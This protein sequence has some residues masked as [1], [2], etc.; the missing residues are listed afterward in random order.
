MDRHPVEEFWSILREFRDYPPDVTGVPE[1]LPGTAAFAASAGLHRPP[2]SYDL[3]PFPFGG[4]MVVGHNLDSRDGYEQRRA[5]GISHGDVVTGTPPMSTW[6][7]LY[8]LVEL[9]EIDVRELFF[10][11]VLV[12]LKAGAPTGPF[13]AHRAPDFRRW[14]REFLERQIVTMRPAVMLVLGTRACRDVSAMANPTPWAG[15]GLPPPTPMSARISGHDTILVA[16]HHTSMQKRIAADAGALRAAW[17]SVR[18]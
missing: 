9:A 11:N 10:T 13:T 7:G 1:L 17:S 2:G 14:C 15:I 16:A 5:L 6:R 3:P 8:R 12:G 18:A 4:L